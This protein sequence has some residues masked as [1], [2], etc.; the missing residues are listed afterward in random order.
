M[1]PWWPMP[2]TIIPLEAAGV[3]GLLVC[4]PLGRLVAG[5]AGHPV[6]EVAAWLAH[7]EC[8]DVAP[9]T[10]PLRRPWQLRLR[11]VAG[12]PHH[13][14]APHDRI[15]GIRSCAATQIGRAHV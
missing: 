5:A 12:D 3:L 1:R 7:G 9:P 2:V 11:P 15:H 4:H 14:V 13:V 8:S 10:S 6:V